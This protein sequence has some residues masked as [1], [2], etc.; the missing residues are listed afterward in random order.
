VFRLLPRLISI[1]RRQVLRARGGQRRHVQVT[2]RDFFDARVL[3]QRRLIQLQ[4][5][6]FDI[7]LAR[8]RLRAFQFDEQVARLVLRVHQRQ[9]ASDQQNRQH[10]IDLAAHAPSGIGKAAARDAHHRRAGARVLVDFASDG[11]ILDSSLSSGC[12]R[13]TAR[14]GRRRSGCSTLA[15]D[16]KK[17]L[18]MRSSSEW[19][20]MMA[21]IAPGA[22]LVSLVQTDSRSSSSLLMKIRIA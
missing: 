6:P 13:S 12:G 5:R 15:L 2:A 8:L 17:R 16:A 1:L 11:F 14:I 3:A 18:T 20:L 21:M 4:L 9:A 19:K 22:R 7:E 10:Q